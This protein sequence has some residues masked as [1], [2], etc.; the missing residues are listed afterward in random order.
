MKDIY[1]KVGDKVY[2][3]MKIVAGAGVVGGTAI[4]MV[5]SLTGNYD[6]N[7]LGENIVLP[8]A[9][10]YFATYAGEGQ[11][12]KVKSSDLE[13]EVEQNHKDLCL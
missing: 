10:Y 11:Y 6:L 7:K 5:G 2:I 13:K 9:I 1:E 4:A 3:A 12:E 8:S